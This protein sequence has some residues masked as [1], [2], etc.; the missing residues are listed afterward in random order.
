MDNDD[1]ISQIPLRVSRDRMIDLLGIGTP[2]PLRDLQVNH[3]QKAQFNQE[4][5]IKL[6][7]KNQ[8]LVKQH[9]RVKI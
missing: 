5:E 3:N 4:L 1:K 2:F 8:Q 6:R 9:D 7:H